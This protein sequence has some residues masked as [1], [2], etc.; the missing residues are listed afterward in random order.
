MIYPAFLMCMSLGVTI[1]LVTFLL[2]KFT[3]IYAGREAVLP[4]P[5]KVLISI[6]DWFSAN[7]VYCATVG[8]LGPVAAA[9][10]LRSERGTRAGHWL[11]LN[12]PLLGRMF[13]QTYLARSVRT[14]GTL[15]DSGVAMLDAVGIT[16]AVVGNRYYQ[17]VWDEV[18][19][20]IQRG[21]QLSAPLFETGLIP[22][23]VTQMIRAGERSGHLAATMERVADFV[24]KDLD[25]TIKR[26]TQLIEPIMILIMGALVGSIVIALL[27][28]IFTISKVLQP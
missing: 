17:D 24:E 12:V 19:T 8:I 22:R 1:F 27:L 20:R 10:Y 18:D 21:E 11:M 9:L 3:T 25:Q 4:M 23:S 13:H 28:P 7:G 5:T 14:L 26:V 6:S 2:P 16:R 15:V